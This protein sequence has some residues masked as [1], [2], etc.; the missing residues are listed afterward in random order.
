MADFT[1]HTYTRLLHALK[2]QGYAFQSFHDYITTPKPKS[3]IFR[4]DVDKRPENALRLAKIESEFGLRGTYYFR[5]K[6]CSWNETIIKEIAELGHEV[7]YHYEDL[8][9]HQGDHQKAFDAF[10]QNLEKLRKLVPVTTICMHGSPTSRYDSRDLWKAFNY[11]ELQI[12]G[13]PYF[14]VDFT[15]VLYLT[16]TGRKWDGQK[17]SI[18]DRVDQD[19]TEKLN[20]Q[21]IRL[22]NTND[23]IEAAQ[24]KLLPDHIMLTIHPQRWHSNKVLWL[25]ELVLQN[26]KNAIKGSML[27]ILPKNRQ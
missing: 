24:K 3:I 5:T 17:V 12:I 4:H 7:G 2:E 10:K 26:L 15:R 9:T 23:I 6:A 14:E 19:Q 8:C 18:R 20:S 1:V 25:K 22:S 16:D 11:K 21:G 27:L 13:E